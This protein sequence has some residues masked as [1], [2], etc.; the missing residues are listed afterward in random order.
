M[1]KNRLGFSMDWLLLGVYFSLLVIGWLAIYSSTHS[2]NPDQN[3]LDLDLP[4]V[5]QTIYIA[6]ALLAF[7][8]GLAVD[9]RFWYTFAYMLY[10]IGLLLLVLVLIVGTEVNGARAWFSL[11]GFSFQPSEL[12]K[13]STIL[14]V[15]SYLNYYKVRLDDLRYQGYILL[16]IAVPIML[17]L[18]Q[19]DAGSAITFF[20]MFILLFV[21]GLNP[22]YFVM[23]V[24][25]VLVFVFSILVPFSWVYFSLILLAVCGAWYYL[26]PFRYQYLL[27]AF[28]T[29]VSIYLFVWMGEASGLGFSSGLFIL[30]LFLLWRSK[31]QKLAFLMP[32]VV[33]FFC[34][35]AVGGQQM[36][37]GLKPHQQERIKVWLKP[38]EC[39][40][41]GSLYNLLQSK[42]AIGS[43]GI[44]GKGFMNGNMTKLKYVPAQSTDFIFSTIGEEHGF[45]GSV[46]VLLLFFALIW[47][48]FTLS[49]QSDYKFGSYFGMAFAGLLGFHVLINIGMTM[50]LVPVVGIPLPFISKGGSSLIIFSLMLGVFLRFQNKSK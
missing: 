18:L 1:S 47:R 20:S 40:P 32:W 45:I 46:V 7:G 5:K 36:F 33:G 12:V 35:F 26:R 17:I 44:F 37:E 15:A 34:L 13:F 38:S 9:S 16:L 28:L 25:M 4:I 27:L 31:Q 6:V 42:V 23:V 22:F 39:D 43:G 21:E 29:A 10:G 3:F 50:G 41:R 19:P 30:S 24:L 49:I 48:I 11:G 14:A 8:I 2:H